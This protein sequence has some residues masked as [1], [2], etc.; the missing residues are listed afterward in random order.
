MFASNLDIAVMMSEEKGRRRGG[1]S[2]QG[3]VMGNVADS[4]GQLAEVGAVVSCLLLI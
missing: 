1:E 4:S 2:R 3:R